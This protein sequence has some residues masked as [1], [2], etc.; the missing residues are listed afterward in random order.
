MDAVSELLDGHRARGAFLLRCVMAAP[1]A[2]RIDDRAAVSVVVMVGGELHL[3]RA[4]DEPLR[5]VSGDVAVVQGTRPY[6]L[7]DDPATPP[8]VVIEPGQRC[9]T[10]DGEDLTIAFGLGLRTWGNVGAGSGGANGFGGSCAFLTGTYELPAQVTGRLLG[11]VPDVVL[12]RAA[13]TDLP[14]ARLL[15]DEFG[16]DAPGQDAV[17]DRL[18]DLVLISALR[19]EFARAGSDAPRW[20]RA[21]E[22]PVIGAALR[23]LHDRPADPWTLG[24][25]AAAV[26][27]SRATLARR[28]TELVGQPPMT[29]LAGR[30]LETAADLLRDTRDS[31]EA[32]GRQVGYANPFGFSTAFRRRYGTSPREYRRSLAAAPASVPAGRGSASR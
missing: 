3:V 7:A 22:D 12:V 32:V 1:W 11:A 9:R 13:D 20:W 30:R 21:Q 25:L 18:T 5:L 28:F 6:L 23:L 17:L 8:T 14:A 16:R 24:D 2:V 29:Y 26:A 15:A 27:V 4:G 10:L 19:A 31:V